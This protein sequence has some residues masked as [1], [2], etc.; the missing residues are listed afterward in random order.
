[1]TPLT[2]KGAPEGLSICTPLAFQPV[3]WSGFELIRSRKEMTKQ[4]LNGERRRDFVAT[5]D[6]LICLDRDSRFEAKRREA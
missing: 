5:G 2:V 1:L 3:A 4:A 6:M